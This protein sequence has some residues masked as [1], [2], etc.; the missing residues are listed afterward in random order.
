MDTARIKELIKQI[1]STWLE[2]DK[3]QKELIK[4]ADELTRQGD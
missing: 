3:A 1:E 2:L 4:L